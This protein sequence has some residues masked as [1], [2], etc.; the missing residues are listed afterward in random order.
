[1]T[2]LPRGAGV[3]PKSSP[4]EIHQTLVDEPRLGRLDNSYHLRL[5][6]RFLGLKRLRVEPTDCK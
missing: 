5:H 3:H 2:G 6:D 4:L 1:M